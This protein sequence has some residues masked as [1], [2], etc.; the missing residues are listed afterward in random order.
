MLPPSYDADEPTESV[1]E[2][3]IEPGLLPN[4]LKQSSI[5]HSAL[6]SVSYIPEIQEMV[7]EGT[8]VSARTLVSQ[9]DISIQ[10]SRDIGDLTLNV[11]ELAN[12]NE[13]PKSNGGKCAAVEARKRGGATTAELKKLSCGPHVVMDSELPLVREILQDT[14]AEKEA[15]KQIGIKIINISQAGLK[16]QCFNVFLF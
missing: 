6:H 9:H 13:K 15:N 8:Q 7:N 2:D 10:M 14:T 16:F 3:E 1:M 5:S 11:N 4:K 12:L